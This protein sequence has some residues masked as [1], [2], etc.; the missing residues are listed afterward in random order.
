MML[1]IGNPAEETKKQKG[2][3]SHVEK[4]KN[5]S[6]RHE[7]GFLQKQGRTSENSGG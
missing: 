1:D 7:N 6:A 4:R 2:A 3:D 5:Q